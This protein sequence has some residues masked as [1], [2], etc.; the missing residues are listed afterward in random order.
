MPDMGSLDGSVSATDGSGNGPGGDG[1]SAAAGDGFGAGGNG[2]GPSTTSSGVT[3]EAVAATGLAVAAAVTAVAAGTP[4]A[5]AIGTLT[6]LGAVGFVIE[7]GG[8][9]LGNA[10]AQG[11]PSA[12]NI[13]T[14]AIEMAQGVT[15]N[16]TDTEAAGVFDSIGGNESVAIQDIIAAA[17]PYY[18][19]GAENNVTLNRFIYAI[20]GMD[21]IEQNTA[22]GY[23]VILNAS[24]AMGVTDT[25][26]AMVDT[27]YGSALGGALNVW[28]ADGNLVTLTPDLQNIAVSR[29]SDWMNEWYNELKPD[30]FPPNAEALGTIRNAQYFAAHSP[31]SGG[32]NT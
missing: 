14:A 8:I 32:G 26:M 7:H 18:A 16:A 11:A 12:V 27:G 20:P 29:V 28:L 25:G 13:G 6:T 10:N 31:G 2:G 17:N 30:G 24:G 3:M 23:S 9:T 4:M 21:Q 22:P 19:I 5:I 15:L 1:P